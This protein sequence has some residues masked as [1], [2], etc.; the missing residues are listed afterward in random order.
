ML[1]QTLPAAPLFG[2]RREMD[3]LFDETFGREHSTGLT[4]VPA[5]DIREDDAALVFEMELAGIAP[6]HVEVTADE[7]LLRIRG[8]KQVVGSTENDQTRWLMSERV[9]GSFQRAFR[10]PNTVDASRIEA[11]FSNG[12]L[13]VRVPKHPTPQPRRIQ[14][15]TR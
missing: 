12:V 13:T 3:R 10:L 8:E 2:L 11:S 6:E 4:W 7:G 9:R 14:I 5:T 1:F 15:E